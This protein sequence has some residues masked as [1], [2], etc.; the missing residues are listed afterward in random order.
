MN[1]KSFLLDEKYKLTLSEKVKN[2]NIVSSALPA[3]AGLIASGV[4][5]AT[6]SIAA[7]LAGPAIA[8]TGSIYLTKIMK[9]FVMNFARNN[10]KELSTENIS[11]EKLREMIDKEREHNYK[12]INDNDLGL[13]PDRGSKLKLN[14]DP[15]HWLSS[16]ATFP[17]EVITTA[18]AF[19]A[20]IL[21]T[22]A[23]NMSPLNVNTTIGGMLAMAGMTALT[24]CSGT[25][26]FKVHEAVKVT[27]YNFVDRLMSR[28][29]KREKMKALESDGLEEPAMKTNNTTK[30]KYS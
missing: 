11:D 12:R 27:S 6:G 14:E 5:V 28:A 19:M 22:N 23:A 29:D 16:F 20:P 18:G 3:A 26:A 7:F 9:Q 24:I 25:L 15:V 10:I 13:F 4:G 2:A 8:V 30:I 1:N 17:S 21:L